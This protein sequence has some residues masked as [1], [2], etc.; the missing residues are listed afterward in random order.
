MPRHPLHPGSF[1]LLLLVGLTLI[2]A[3]AGGCDKNKKDEAER[4]KLQSEQEAKDQ[5]ARVPQDKFEASDD[6]PF[7]AETRFAAGQLAESQGDYNVAIIQYR[8]ALKIDPNHQP[9]LFRLGA[10]YTQ[11]KKFDEAIAAWQSY[12]KVTKNAPAAY[13]NLAFC[14]E[15]AGRTAEAEQTYKAGISKD[16]TDPA[17]R[18]NYGLMLARQGRTD[19]ATAQLASALTPAEVQYNLGSVAEQAGKKDQA[20]AY[21]MKALELDPKLTDAKSRLARLK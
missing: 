1:A 2:T 8:E 19:E 10:A 15:T 3:P 21:Y 6:P 13:N 7:N 11:K 4:K 20:K 9:T 14:Y 12:L 16:P 18:I 17:C 5:A